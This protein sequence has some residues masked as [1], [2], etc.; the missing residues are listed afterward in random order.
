[1]SRVEDRYSAGPNGLT[2]GD[3]LYFPVRDGTHCQW[4]LE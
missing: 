1:M 3:A 4:L 2:K